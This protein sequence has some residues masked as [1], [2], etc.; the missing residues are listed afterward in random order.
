MPERVEK[1]RTLAQ[2]LAAEL[3]ASTT[4]DPQS[5]ES[6]AAIVGDLRAALDR[7]DVEP[8]E[9][10]TLTARFRA[11]EAEFQVS[12]PTIS[13]LILRMIDALGQLGI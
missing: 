1:L 12:H 10:D 7:L 3:D 6:L 8:I 2:E 9:S 13:G 5:R 4:S 11:A